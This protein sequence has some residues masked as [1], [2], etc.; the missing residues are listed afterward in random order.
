[1][2]SYIFTNILKMILLKLSKKST[3]NNFI[4]NMQIQKKFI[5][6]KQNCNAK[7]ESLTIPNRKRSESS[8]L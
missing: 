8:Q 7:E 6:L 1:M 4:K 2:L 5:F 3:K